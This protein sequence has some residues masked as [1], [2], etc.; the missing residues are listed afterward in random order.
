LRYVGDRIVVVSGL[1][2]SGKST[3][4]AALEDLSFYC[5]DNLPAPLLEQFL[6]LCTQ[7]TP[8]IEKIAL[9]IDARE[10]SFFREVPAVI[11]QLRGSGAAVEVIFLDCS[12][13]VLINR[14]RETRR[15][16]PLSPAGSVEE[17]I[18]KERRLLV[19]IAGLAD[20]RI[21]TSAFNVHQLKAAVVQ[22]VAGKARPTVVNLISFGFRYGTPST[23]ELLFDVRFLPNPYFDSRM[24]DLTGR[25]DD[26]AD[27]VLK[28][29]RG[30]A[31]FERLRDLCDFLLPLYDGEGKA[32]VTIGVG[33]TG[34]RHRSVAVVEALAESIRRDGREVNLEHRDMERNS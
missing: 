9:T 3:A 22:L 4:M 30:S 7:A 6:H 1:S 28:N 31:L 16:H 5:L 34:G 33:C 18:D 19:D 27:F 21:E 20:H 32:Y 14:Y 23:A 13:E 10:A 2:G 17:G 26:V 25:N 11:E 24:R 12:E 8:P 29:P 15:V